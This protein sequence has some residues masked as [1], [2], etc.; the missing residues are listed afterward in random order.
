MLNKVRR[1]IGLLRQFQKILPRP[2]LIT[3]YKSF[4]R[5]HLVI[6]ILSMIE[7]I[8]FLLKIESNQYNTTLAITGAIR[9]TFREKFYYELRFEP[10]VSRGWYHK[11][12]CFYNVFQTQS[13]RSPI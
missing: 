4:I 10:L 5:S 12:F 13:P 1:T 11:L 8:T 3:I 6:E 2:P 9:G 7:P